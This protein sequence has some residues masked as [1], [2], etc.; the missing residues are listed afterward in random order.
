MKSEELFYDDLNRVIGWVE[1]A[2]TLLEWAS[3]LSVSYQVE[4]DASG[5]KLEYLTSPRSKLVVIE[6][7]LLFQDAL[8]CMTTVLF[9]KAKEEIGMPYLLKQHKMEIMAKSPKYKI[10]MDRAQQD[11]RAAN[12]LEMRHTLFAHKNRKSSGDALM[13]YMNRVL[14]IHFNSMREVISTL[15]GLLLN[16]DVPQNNGFN[17]YFGDAYELLKER[18]ELFD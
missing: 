12:L 9:G 13:G 2:E 18:L 17:E 10:R 8:L 4:L 11:F 5:N 1:R 3:E 7:N 6:I 15:K 16:F 14:H